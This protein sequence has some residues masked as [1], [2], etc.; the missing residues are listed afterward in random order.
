M[1]PRT[2]VTELVEVRPGLLQARAF[3]L[4]V[5]F[6]DS[7]GAGSKPAPIE[8][9]GGHC[10]DRMTS[11]HLPSTLVKSVTHPVTVSTNLSSP[12]LRKEG[13]TRISM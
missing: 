3:A 7:V 8:S 13:K 2:V 5:P 6:I 1:A 12:L 10:P 11:G 9:C 4:G